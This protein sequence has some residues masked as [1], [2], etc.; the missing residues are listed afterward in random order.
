MLARTETIIVNNNVPASPTM[1]L[2]AF[3]RSA[4]MSIMSLLL[5]VGIWFLG[6]HYLE[7]NGFDIG[8]RN[9]GGT[10][11]YWIQAISGFFRVQLT[12]CGIVSLDFFRS[13]SCLLRWQFDLLLFNE[14]RLAI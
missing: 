5:L 10:I 12:D 1:I 6:L 7:A 2:N 13:Y 4:W 3:D 9:T 11:L 8:K 14:S